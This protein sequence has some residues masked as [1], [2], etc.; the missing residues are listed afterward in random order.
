MNFMMSPNV[1][2]TTTNFTSNSSRG[3]ILAMVTVMRS[4][5]PTVPGRKKRTFFLSCDI[6]C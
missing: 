6:I 3:S 2:P 4:A 1:L 5:P